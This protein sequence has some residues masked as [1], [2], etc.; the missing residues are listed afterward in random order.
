M[1]R[2]KPRFLEFWT[3]YDSTADKTVLFMDRDRDGLVD[4]EDLKLEFDGNLVSNATAALNL[5]PASF[6]AGTIILKLGT[7]G[8]DSNTNPALGNDVDLAYGLGGNDTLDGLEGDDTLNGDAGDDV[9]SGGLDR[10]SLFGGC[11]S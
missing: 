2:L 6:S 11:R 5:G 8:A 9:L 7:S 4:A 1:A 10:D 3:F